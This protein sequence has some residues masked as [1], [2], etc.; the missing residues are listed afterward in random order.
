MAL[1]LGLFGAAQAYETDQ[2][3]N[4]LQV[5]EDSKPILNE[6]V[7]EAIAQVIAKWRWKNDE[8]KFAYKV[9]RIL[10]GRH[11]VDHI[12]R[13]AMNSDEVAKI[14]VP[15]RG[16]IYHRQP[17]WATRI[18]FMLGIGA[19]VKV[20]GTLFGT[21]KLGHFFSQGLKYYRR[22]RR[23][24]SEAEAATQSALTERALFGKMTT[25]SYSNADLVANYE[26]HRFYRSLFED[27]II[28]GKP[29]ILIW[30]GDQWRQQRPFDW[31]DHV[32]DYWDEALNINHFDALL[33]HYIVPRLKAFCPD[34]HEKP[35]AFAIRN[36]DELKQRYQDLQLVDSSELRLDQLCVPE[37]SKP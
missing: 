5:I 34:F 20:D 29:A 10:G 6:K 37:P 24:D 15:R 26:G 36:E 9:Y 18:G 22:F 35:E 8:K 32:N 16:S 11:W 13:W 19:T 4:R 1:A 25:G 30:A 7:N 2:F 21:D 3:T 33:K 23:S 14:E 28:D 31:A 17:I 12:E 27:N